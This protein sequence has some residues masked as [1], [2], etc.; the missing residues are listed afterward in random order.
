MQIAEAVKI[1]VHGPLA[2]KVADSHV[3]NL[4]YMIADDPPLRS[5]R[6]LDSTAQILRRDRMNVRFG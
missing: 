5:K 3:N 4:I 2:A 6:F 1:R